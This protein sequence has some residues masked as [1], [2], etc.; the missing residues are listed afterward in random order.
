MD[1][2]F[3][4]VVT[5]SVQAMSIKYNTMVYE[6]QRQGKKVIVMSL[7]EAFFDIPLFDMK[8]L[9]NPEIFHYSHSRGIPEL[10]EKLAEYFILNYDIPINYEKEILIT[11]GSKAA[12]HFAL[13]SI[14][15]PGDEV[16]IQEPAW[17]SY[18]EQV[19]LCYAKPV[20]VPYYH[21]ISDYEDYIT[22]NTKAIIICNPHN[23]SG[24]VYSEYDITH[25]LNLA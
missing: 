17:V 12:I 16:I 21:T 3:S 25:L 1:S 2:R 5:R 22:E 7:G 24:Y 20:Q 6:L 9:P 19:K 14:L 10:R 23:P 4:Q 15:N 18:P 8:E 11:A 13:M